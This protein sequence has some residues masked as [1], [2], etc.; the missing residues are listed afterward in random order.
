MGSWLRQSSS[1]RMATSIRT[2][3]D[4]GRHRERRNRPGTRLLARGIDPAVPRLFI[5]DGAKALSKA[6]RRT[7]RQAAAVRRCQVHKT[8]NI[9]ERLRRLIRCMFRS[10]VCCDKHGSWTM[11][12]KPKR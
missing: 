7:F 12:T 10:G 5:I 3:P 4:R 6:V 2:W 1:T 8:R 9:M 11:P